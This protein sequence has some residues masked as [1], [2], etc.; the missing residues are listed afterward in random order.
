MKTHKNRV[1]GS[2]ALA[3]LGNSVSWEISVRYL[4][5]A[6]F[7]KNKHRKAERY[8][9]IRLEHSVVKQ[10]LLFQENFLMNIKTNIRI[11]KKEI[12]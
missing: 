5:V 3:T 1:S 6:E 10:M 7:S 2:K 11:R 12:Y 4:C 8:H 9:S